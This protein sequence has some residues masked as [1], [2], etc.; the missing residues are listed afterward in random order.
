M[1]T[2][3]PVN[4]V[5]LGV[6]TV[7]A[8]AGP[9]WTAFWELW[10]FGMQMNQRLLQPIGGSGSTQEIETIAPP[11]NEKDLQTV[12]AAIERAKQL[13]N[14]RRCYEALKRYGVA[15]IRGA[16]NDLRVGGEPDLLD[17]SKGPNVFDG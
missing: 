15:D 6:V 13:V 10:V 12:A 17:A 8:D 4:G 2:V 14:K 7:R 16:V 3:G 11:F 1:L 5:Q 9:D